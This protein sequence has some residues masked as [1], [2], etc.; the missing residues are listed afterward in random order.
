MRV[1]IEAGR[2]TR[3]SFDWFAASSLPSPG[4]MAP[5]QLAKKFD[6]AVVDLWNDLVEFAR[7]HN[8]L[9][10]QLQHLLRGLRRYFLG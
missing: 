1:G 2:G 7:G 6:P 5:E 10:D 9:A 8:E 4:L 3:R